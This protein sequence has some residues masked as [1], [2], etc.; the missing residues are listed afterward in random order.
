VDSRKKEV[1]DVTSWSFF[2]LLFGFQVVSVP[3]EGGSSMVRE[4]EVD[5]ERR[6]SRETRAMASERDRQVRLRSVAN[7]TWLNLP[8]SPPMPDGEEFPRT[9]PMHLRSYDQ[10][11]PLLLELDIPEY[12][13]SYVI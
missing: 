12:C 2:L 11:R 6:R 1:I 10:V 8:V 9:S 7:D 5:V 4:S 3:G 13:K